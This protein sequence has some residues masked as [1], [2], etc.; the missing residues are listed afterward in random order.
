M[1]E[2][3][4]LSKQNILTFPATSILLESK[5]FMFLSLSL[6]LAAALSE[7]EKDKENKTNT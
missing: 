3:P 1:N 4:V 7:K 5:Q 6:L 2:L